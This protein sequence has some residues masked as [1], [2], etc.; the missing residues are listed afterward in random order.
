MRPGRP[1]RQSQNSSL[2][3]SSLKDA[4]KELTGA[5]AK[6]IEGDGVSLY[7]IEVGLEDGWYYINDPLDYDYGGS[8]DLAGIQK[9]LKIALKEQPNWDPV[10][11][12]AMEDVERQVSNL[13]LGGETTING[14]HVSRVSGGYK[15]STPD[16]SYWHNSRLPDGALNDAIRTVKGEI[17]SMGSWKK[18]T[19]TLGNLEPAPF[20]DGVG[21]ILR[22]GDRVSIEG[23]GTLGGVGSNG[24]LQV[25][26]PDGKEVLVPAKQVFPQGVAI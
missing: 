22:G 3:P 19:I 15:V 8:N 5:A 18:N 9:L 11:Q 16:N 21:K 26:L 2:R 17:T 13:S 24:R 10:Y 20:G 6:L 25:I 14:V 12:H 4:Q 23:G 7:Q 1:P